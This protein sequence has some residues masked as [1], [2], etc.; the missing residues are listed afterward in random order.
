MRVR[1]GS[2]SKDISESTYIEAVEA[3]NAATLEICKFVYGL[4]KIKGG[5]V[6][7]IG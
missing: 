3:F 2:Q 7:F 4:L 1:I 5:S 6:D